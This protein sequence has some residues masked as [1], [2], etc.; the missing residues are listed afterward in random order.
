MQIEKCKKVRIVKKMKMKEKNVW[1]GEK[2]F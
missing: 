2:N 1:N